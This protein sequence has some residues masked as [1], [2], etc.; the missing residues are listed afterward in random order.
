[1]HTG[2]CTKGT[3]IIGLY[4]F[5]ENTVIFSIHKDYSESTWEYKRDGYAP[6]SVH[7]PSIVEKGFLQYLDGCPFYKYQKWLK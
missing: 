7:Y 4:A 6:T 1:M 3:A 5:S 2:I